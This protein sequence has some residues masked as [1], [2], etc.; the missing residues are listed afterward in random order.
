VG[1]VALDASVVIGLIDPHDAHHGRAVADLD[2][3][4]DRRDSLL[5]PS[6][7]YAE[8]L[9]GP[10]R[11]DQGDLVDGFMDDAGVT[12]V[13][14]TRELARAAA[15]LRA[16]HASLRLADALALAVAEGS[17]AR[18][19]TYDHRLLRIAREAGS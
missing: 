17:G 11:R 4:G 6:S 1:S 8:A 18:L 5:I 15:L 19:L 3:C 9:V 14:L 7:A 13:A 12:V 16:K 2:A 10:M